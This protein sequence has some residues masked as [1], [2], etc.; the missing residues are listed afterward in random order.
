MSRLVVSEAAH[1]D[2]DGIL[3]YLSAVLCNP[4]AA[5]ALAGAVARAYR[6][7]LTH[8]ESSPLCAH[9]RLAALGYRK[10][11]VRNYLF[12]YRHLPEEDTVFVARFFHQSRNYA[13]LL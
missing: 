11:P 2:L 13:D 1:A 6:R 7:I 9:P 8:P 3:A 5:T 10:V 4:A 12:V